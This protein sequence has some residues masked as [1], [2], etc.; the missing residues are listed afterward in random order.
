M[1][2]GPGESKD[3]SVTLQLPNEIPPGVFRG[4]LVFRGFL[5]EGV[6]VEITIE[7]STT[8]TGLGSSEEAQR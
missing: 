3:L 2:I 6:P 5:V 7:G 8:D 1:I 4:S